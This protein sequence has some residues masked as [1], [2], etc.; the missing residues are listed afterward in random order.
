M[1]HRY[2]INTPRIR[3]QSE[4]AEINWANPAHIVSRRSSGD[5]YSTDDRATYRT[6]CPAVTI[7]GTEH[8]VGSERRVFGAHQVQPIVYRP[9]SDDAGPRA[10]LP[11]GCPWLRVTSGNRAAETEQNDGQVRSRHSARWATHLWGNRVK[12]GGELG[13]DNDL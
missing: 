11:M 1:G 13:R 6:M 8:S 10:P 3:L 7:G 2:R 9:G 12:S 5:T 4:L